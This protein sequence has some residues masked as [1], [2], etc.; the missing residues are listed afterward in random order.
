[1]ARF[2]ITLS[3]LAFPL[4]NV[5]TAF[6]DQTFTY[7][8]DYKNWPGYPE[9][10][11]LLLD[12]D[13]IGTNP[14]FLGMQVVTDDDGWLKSVELSGWNFDSKM[15]LFVNGEWNR[16]GEAYDSWDYYVEMD[17]GWL[18]PATLYSVDDIY[19]YGLV[20]DPPPNPPYYQ[21]RD[22]HPMSIVS[23]IS[24]IGIVTFSSDHGVYGTTPGT[25]TYTFAQNTVRLWTNEHPNFVVGESVICANDV[26]LSPLPEPGILSLLGVGL[27]S[28]GL[29]RR[30][31]RN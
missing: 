24:P 14:T 11:Y 18:Q 22:G 2:L 9:S 27:L 16:G 8:D 15:T 17:K 30:Q 19:A 29:A 13:Q 4:L 23:G 31:V 28:L 26:L 20:T 10:P 1:M 3:L 25:F 21:W 5:G 12:V 6:A 7:G